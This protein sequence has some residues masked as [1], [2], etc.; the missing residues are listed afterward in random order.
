[1][2]YTTESK[3]DQNWQ[4]GNKFSTFGHLRELCLKA[5]TL[6]LVGRQGAHMPSLSEVSSDPLRRSRRP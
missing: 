4:R 2:I 6:A 3:A 1:M 5:L